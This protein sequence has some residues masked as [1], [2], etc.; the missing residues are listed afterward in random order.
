MKI[1]VLAKYD[2]CQ[3]TETEIFDIATSVENANKLLLTDISKYQET[4][5][6]MG[7]P[8][9][10]IKELKNGYEFN[11]M[12]F[13]YRQLD[14]NPQIIFDLL[15]ESTVIHNIQKLS[16]LWGKSEF[17]VD[18][19]GITGFWETEYE[20]NFDEL[21]KSMQYAFYCYAVENNLLTVTPP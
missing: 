11:Y 2:R 10:K 3:E 8:V 14:V 4:L 7:E 17:L 18:Y 5:K 6:I 12:E 15:Y 19:V 1:F 9:P 20:K 13:T 16:E 21:Q